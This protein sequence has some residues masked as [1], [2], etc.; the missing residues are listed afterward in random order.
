MAFFRLLHSFWEQLLC[1]E[2]GSHGLQLEK[3][4]EDLCRSEP[5]QGGIKSILEIMVWSLSLGIDHLLW[6]RVWLTDIFSITENMQ[7]WGR[8]LFLSFSSTTSGC[9]FIFLSQCSTPPTSVLV[10]P[11]SFCSCYVLL[12]TVLLYPSLCC[13]SLI[14]AATESLCCLLLRGGTRHC[15]MAD[16]VPGKVQF[17]PQALRRS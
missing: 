5:V 13:L 6:E 14:R 16:A 10:L 4:A 3:G 17:I 1:S 2:H 8:T 15:S 11:L 12:N 7:G 9:S